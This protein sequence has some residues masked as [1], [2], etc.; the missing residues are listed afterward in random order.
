M[1]A[2]TYHNG[3]RYYREH[4]ASRSHGVCTVASGSI[5]CHIADNQVIQLVENIELGDRWLDEVLAIISIK[6][7][8]ERVAK[9]KQDIQQRLRR[10]AKTYLDGLLDDA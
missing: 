8:A 1:W 7:E 2:Q 5:P 6:D 10:M 3:Q 9:K 4:K